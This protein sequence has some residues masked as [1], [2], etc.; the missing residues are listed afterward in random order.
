MPYV[1]EHKMQ[2]Q[3][4]FELFYLLFLTKKDDNNIGVRNYY[5]EIF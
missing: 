5:H 1:F 4:A 2:F 3:K